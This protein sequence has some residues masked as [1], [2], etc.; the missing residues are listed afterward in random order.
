MTEIKEN[1]SPSPHQPLPRQNNALYLR[2]EILIRLAK[3]F[4]RNQLVESVDSIPFE[5]RPKGADAPFRCCI[6]KERAILRLRCIAGLGFSVEEDDD[7]TPLAR[8]AEQALEDR[9]PALPVLTV[10]DIACK[11]CVDAH[12]YVTELCQGC[13]ARPCYAGCNFGAISIVD[14]RSVIDRSKCRNCG[15]C[16]E[17][18]PYRAIVKFHVPCE[19]ACPVAAIH[20]GTGGRA[21]IDDDRCT[22]CGRCMR[23]CP[24]GA[25]MERSQ[26]IDVLRKIQAGRRVVALVAPAIVGQFPCSLEKIAGGIKKLGMSDVLSV[27][28]G[29]DLTAISEAK[30]FVE[31]MKKGEPFMTTSCCPAYTQTARKHLPEILPMI[32][33]TPTPMHFTAQWARQLF[34]DCVTV[35]IGP[36]VAKRA[37]GL[38]DPLVDHVLTFEELGALFVAMGIELDEMEPSSL[39]EASAQGRGFAVTGGVAQAVQVMV[40][41]LPDEP[42]KPTVTPVCVNGL[43]PAGIKLLKTYTKGSC[44]GNLVEIMTCEGGCVAGA[45]TLGNP[46]VATREIQKGTAAA[47]SLPDIQEKVPCVVHES[48][49]PD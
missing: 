27:A 5:M 46:K 42:G 12:Y 4:L 48:A 45:G 31:R 15:R 38:T 11:G 25:I 34:P 39:F 33:G 9:K 26:I 6:D 14:G 8:Y 28:V 10:I 24:F 49:S 19:E 37:E 16:M 3:S 40:E 44:P 36:C 32:S 23:A 43:S 18:C 35:F 17:L 29:A 20:K 21:I 41:S 2:R 13:L 30:E 1:Q 47:P 7:V 22:S